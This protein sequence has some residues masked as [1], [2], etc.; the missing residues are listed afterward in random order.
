M[1]D[2]NIVSELKEYIDI[3]D[4]SVELR[5][6]NWVIIN[7]LIQVVCLFPII[8]FLGGIYQNASASID[9]LKEQQKQLSE[10]NSWRAT[11]EQW[12]YKIETWARSKGYGKD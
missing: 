5:V 10:N 8:F 7:V 3:R 11:R 4:K 2:D 9:L 1:S 12:E 6:K